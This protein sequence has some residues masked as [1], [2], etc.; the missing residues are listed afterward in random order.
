MKEF[1]DHNEKEAFVQGVFSNIARHYDLMN[2]V[3]SFGQD[4]F[5]RK[6]AV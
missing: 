1:K 3:L 2:T 6:F 4:Y 5:W